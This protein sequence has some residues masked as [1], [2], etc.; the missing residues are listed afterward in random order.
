MKNTLTTV[1]ALLICAV[2]HAQ[3]YKTQQLA[4]ETYKINSEGRI[5][6]VSRMMVPVTVPPGTK[7]LYYTVACSPKG[8]LQE[9]GLHT[10]AELVKYARQMNLTPEE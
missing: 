3:H 2:A 9:L 7:Y 4:K 10:Q 5:G 8:A 1:V 6:G